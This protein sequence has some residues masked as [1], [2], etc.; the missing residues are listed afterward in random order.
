MDAF[1]HHVAPFQEQGEC[2]KFYCC[3]SQ[4]FSL[5]DLGFTHSIDKFFLVHHEPNLW[6][7]LATY[8]AFFSENHN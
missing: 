3:T 4:A 2:F 7:S 5:L 1:Y 8:G 6:A